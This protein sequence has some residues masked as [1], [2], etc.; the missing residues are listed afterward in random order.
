[1][2]DFYYLIQ[3]IGYIG[4]NYYCPVCERKLRKFKSKSCPYC[5]AGI[6][7]R[8]LWFFLLR[9]T[10]FFKRKLDVLHI[11]PEHCFFKKMKKQQNINYLSADLNSPRA[12]VKIDITN[13]VPRRFEWVVKY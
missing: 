8:T 7:H 13:M 3:S 12:M 4:N 5:G 9:K 6:R 1:L 10:N 11:A 2:L